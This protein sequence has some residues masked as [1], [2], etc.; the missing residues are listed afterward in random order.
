MPV[1]ILARQSKNKPKLAYCWVLAGNMRFYDNWSFKVEYDHIWF[2]DS[3][4]LFPSTESKG[5][6]GVKN[7]KDIVKV[8]LNYRF[9]SL[10]GLF[11]GR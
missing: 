11:G 9:G 2:E 8:G 5:M 3:Q 10:F 4:V 6:F 1:R 7:S